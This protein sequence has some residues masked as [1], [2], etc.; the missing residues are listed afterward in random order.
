[1][2]ATTTITNAE[3]VIVTTAISFA[4]VL[5]ITFS[6]RLVSAYR[7]ELPTLAYY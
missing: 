6:F 1:M 2:V 5:V 4:C 3:A 7:V